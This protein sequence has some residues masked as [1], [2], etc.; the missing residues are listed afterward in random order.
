ML[1][2]KA[3]GLAC[4]LFWAI[5]VFFLAIFNQTWPKIAALLFEAYLAPW[6]QASAGAAAPVVLALLAFI[7]GFLGGYIFAWLYDWVAKKWK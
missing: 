1:K 2:P 6:W 5:A 7:D 3:F 4:G